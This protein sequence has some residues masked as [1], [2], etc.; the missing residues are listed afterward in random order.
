MYGLVGLTLTCGVLAP[1]AQA[2]AD[3]VPGTSTTPAAT[4]EP[5]ATT[6]VAKAEA[7]Q[8]ASS[9]ARATKQPVPV[10]ELTTETDTVTALPDGTMSLKRTVAPARTK[11]TG[12]WVDLDPTLKPSTDGKV[13]PI[14]TTDDLVLGGGGDNML[15]SM[16]T[17]GRTLTLTWPTTLP[18]PVLDGAGALYPGVLPDVDLKVTAAEQGGFA[19]TL[20]VKTPDAARNPKLATLKL[21]T[22]GTG[23]TVAPE[24]G[25]AL[26]AKDADGSRVFAA[27]VPQ[28]W[29][30]RT[31]AKTSTARTANAAP[32]AA[33]V[34]EV[35][36]SELASTAQ[37]P[38]ARATHAD[39]RTSVDKGSVTLSADTGLLTSPDTVFPV[40]IDPSWSRPA[41]MWGWVQS[42]Y[43]TTPGYGRTDYQPGIGY[44]RWRD[45]V[46]IE[47]SFFRVSVDGL[48][49]KDV[50]SASFNVKQVDSAMFS[51]TDSPQPVSLKAVSDTLTTS[52]NWNN[53][54]SGASE[55]ASGSFP[56]S[57]ADAHCAPRLLDFSITDQIAAR[58]HWSSVTFGL[59]GNETQSTSNNGFKRVSRTAADTFLSVSYNTPPNPP[60]NLRTDPAPVN[61]SGAN[62]CGYIGRLNPDVGRLR[63]MA[64]RNDLDGDD[65]DVWFALNEMNQGG[66]EVWNSGWTSW[67]ANGATAN[68]DVPSTNSSPAAPTA[69]ASRAATADANPAG[70]T[71]A[72]S[73]STA[74]SPPSPASPAPT[75]P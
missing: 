68:A 12:K 43:E 13:R 19:H 14:S 27:P 7:E 3:A 20:I 23:L 52:T 4:T 28:M 1:G 6:P 32:S 73:P 60:T 48:A 50:L 45:R 69:G 64:D 56:G 11:K 55:W 31:T 54:P 75:T 63:L 72:T 24:A 33:D 66:R 15:A 67:G 65:G 51:C 8:S 71:A 62:N 46:G 17:G 58:T 10:P 34:G 26:V 42:A 74:P 16:T 39:L 57:N 25:G 35:P 40:Y 70:P 2:A 21:G 18:R 37:R 59:F 38:G 44:Q 49:G 36:A 30:S 5:Q 9:K 41:A 47:R 61:G 53:Q 29:D 22:A